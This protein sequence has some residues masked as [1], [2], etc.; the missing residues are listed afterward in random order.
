MKVQELSSPPRASTVV[1]DCAKACLRSTYQLLFDNCAELYAR[2]FQVDP[3]KEEANDEVGPSLNNLDFWHKHIALMVS[4]IEE[5]RASYHPVL[6][7]F[8]QELNI[9]HLSAATMWS[10]FAVDMKYA[11]EEHE[12][13]RLCRSSAYMNLHFKVKWL[14]ITYCKDVPQFKDQVPEYPA[15]FEPFVM[16]WLNENDDVSLEYLNSAFLRDK[17]D[18]FQQSSEHSL[19]SNSVV[20][21]FTQLTQCFDVISKLE[22]PDPEIVKRYMKRFAKTIV[23][24][25]TTYAEILKKDFHNYVAQETTS[26]ILMNN[27]QQLRVQ[28]EKMFESMGGEKLEPDAASILQ[29]L[30]QSL[31]CV[32]DDLSAVFALSLSGTI[33]QSVQELS[34]LLMTVKGPGSA[35]N[36]QQLKTQADV[37]AEADHI[38][39]PLMDLLDGKLSLFAQYC[40]RTVLKRLLKELWKLVIHTLEKTCVLPPT[41]EKNIL[42]QGLPSAK[43]EDMTKL[44]KNNMSGGKLPNLGAAMEAGSKVS[45][46]ATANIYVC[47][48]L[49]NKS[50]KRMA[51]QREAKSKKKKR[52][53]IE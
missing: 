18:G 29:E 30:Q 13:H 32:L 33:R 20:D 41:N 23:K 8:P 26:C 4:V 52:I 48:E 38:L 11:L 14:Y 19:F 49:V 15:W 51:R 3:T 31:N 24:V 35:A 9:G 1:K 34:A 39:A 5:D 44:F 28:L 25:L 16:Q 21:V 40:E 17:K 45:S 50:T 27:V 12:Q 47:V 42:L 7:Q 36:Q 53:E 22:C 2:E 10:L 6:N 37:A 43:I 46:H